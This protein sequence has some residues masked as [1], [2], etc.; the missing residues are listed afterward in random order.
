ML[1]K[2]KKRISYSKIDRT[3]LLNFLKM[4]KTIKMMIMLKSAVFKLI[5][6]AG[7]ETQRRNRSFKTKNERKLLR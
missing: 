4:M 7:K 3:Q 2:E 6:K 1:L 5:Q